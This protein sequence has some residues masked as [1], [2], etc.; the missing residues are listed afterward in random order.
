VK[1]TLAKAC[2][3]A[4]ATAILAAGLMPAYAVD[5]ISSTDAPDL[6]AP[7]A[8]IKAKDW[9]GAITEL[10]KIAETTTHADVYSLLGFSLRNAGQ[11]S[12]AKVYYAK[13]LDFD[14]AHK[15]A[16]EYLGELYVK[17]GDMAKAE[18]QLAILEKLCPKGCEEL[19]DLKK[20]IVEAKTSP[21]AR[22]N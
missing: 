8:K 22:T 7:R 18:A 17:V 16:H 11:I 20:H 9:A 6:A 12:E 2:A 3:T 1:S 10:K 5:T 13:A 15:G 14:P 4:L 21:G 19:A